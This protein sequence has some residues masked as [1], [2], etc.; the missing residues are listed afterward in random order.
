MSEHRVVHALIGKSAEN[1]QTTLATV[2]GV[3]LVIIG[4]LS[5]SFGW[6][7]WNWSKNVEKNQPY[8]C[9]KP[10]WWVGA[11]C[12]ALI[13]TAVDAFSYSLLPLSQ[14]A[15]FGA[16]P[17][18]WNAII[19]YFGWLGSDSEKLGWT[20]FVAFAFIIAGVV[21]VGLTTVAAPVQRKYLAD[22]Q[23]EIGGTGFI[24]FCS[25]I[26]TGSAMWGSLHAWPW[27]RKVCK[28]DEWDEAWPMLVTA[29][30]TAAA[31]AVTQTF[32]KIISE[33]I[34]ELVDGASVQ[35]L[36]SQV[37]PWIGI[38]GGI[39]FAASNFV[40]LQLFFGNER[41]V[42]LS[43]PAYQGLVII[44]TTIAGVAFLKELEFAPGYGI[45]I[46]CVGVALI[47]LGLTPLAIH[48]QQVMKQ[49]KEVSAEQAEEANKKAE[50]GKTGDGDQVDKAIKTSWS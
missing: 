13:P 39:L 9:G 8:C 12:V 21:C 3:I 5:V 18:V 50:M 25:V 6:H 10:R 48:Q 27:L 30:L 34:R 43:L 28:L 33:T 45:A 22:Y 1:N 7:F 19:S 36:A 26:L 2:F 31:A 35:S 37:T 46:F 42:S 24:V 16:L 49:R 38:F 29:L 20:D 32:V 40:L 11:V 15:A 14:I 47:L 4:T 41:A 17:I 23:E 44:F